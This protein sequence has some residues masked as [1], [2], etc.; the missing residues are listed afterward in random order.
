[1]SLLALVLLHPHSYT[2]QRGLC[3]QVPDAFGLNPPSQL[4]I[5]YYHWLT[6]LNLVQNSLR[7]L[8]NS[9][10]TTNIECII[11]HISKTK[12]R[13]HCQIQCQNSFQNMVHLLGHFFSTQSSSLIANANLEL[14]TISLVINQV[15]SNKISQPA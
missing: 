7:V 3:P 10:F 14:S 8:S 9:E 6:F 12:N 13:N 11:D 15:V 1:M 5:G 4:V 2:L